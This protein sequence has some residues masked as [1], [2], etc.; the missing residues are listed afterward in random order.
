M[1]PPRLLFGLLV[2]S[3]S[4][5]LHAQ[6]N[7]SEIEARIKKVENNLATWVQADGI[8]NWNIRERMKF[9]N[10]H[11]V[12]IAVINDYKIEWAKGYGIADTSGKKKVTTHTLFQA[13][14]AS[15]SVAAM[16]VLKLVQEGKIDPAKDINTYLSSW[17]FPYDSVSNGKKI[18]VENLLNHTGGLSTPS[19]RGYT[20]K[21]TIPT[22]VQILDGEKPAQ[23][24]KVRSISEPGLKSEYSGGGYEIA[25]LLVQDVTEMLFEDYMQKNV[26]QPLG[27]T[28][29]TFAQPPPAS[30][31]PLLAAGYYE[32]GMQV[33][34]RYKIYPE[35]AAGGMW[36]TPTD[37][38]KYIVEMQ[39]SLQGRSNKVLSKEMA[40]HS[41]VTFDSTAAMGNYVI[42][43][44]GAKYFAHGGGNEGFVCQFFGSMESGKGVV[45]MANNN[46]NRLL[47][48]ICNSVAIVY[49]WS[50]FYRPE[51]KKTIE[52]PSDSLDRFV[53]LY[54]FQKF[55][56]EIIKQ[57]GKLF[58]SVGSTPCQL[59]FTDKDHFFLYEWTQSDFCFTYDKDHNVSHI[60]SNDKIIA[61][62]LK[63][64]Q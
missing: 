54:K 61:Y 24:P 29:S 12:S 32:N 49:S 22:L 56:L 64:R 27:M 51:H 35:Q 38:A 50:N 59:H 19:F 57:N 25:Q 9:Y 37:L 8:P 23:G 42:N 62:H 36:S 14:S 53:G 11:G 44:S 6:K 15:K 34:G 39:L 47:D 43:R 45:V 13:A 5:S 3:L 28:Q 48:E 41:L 46:S 20:S 16:G 18:N 17:K 7:T 58:L 1:I 21:D 26:L 30:K 10:T 40:Q 33:P 4:L 55:T 63:P 31:K 60:R 2:G 52:L